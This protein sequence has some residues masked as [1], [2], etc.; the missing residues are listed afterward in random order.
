MILLKTEGLVTG[1]ILLCFC[2]II[3]KPVA[4]ANA[5]SYPMQVPLV[6]KN[7]ARYDTPENAYTAMISS[8]IQKDIE[9]YYDGLTKKTLEKEASLAEKYGTDDQIVFDSVNDIKSIYIL[10]RKPYKN[11]VLLIV[12][13]INNDESILQGPSIF[14]R[15]NGQ[16]KSNQETFSAEDPILDYLEYI[17]PPEYLTLWEPQKLTINKWHYLRS[18]HLFRVDTPGEGKLTITKATLDK[19][20]KNGF[21]FFNYRRI[22]LR[23]FFR[24]DEDTLEK[25]IVLRS[26]NKII[27]FLRGTPGAAITLKIEQK[28]E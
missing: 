27:L 9:W 28:K 2:I 12:K 20:I 26:K 4:V 8:L 3:F 22:P 10:D 16:W 5:A 25:K 11:G 1:A 6:T 18:S 24:G 13:T 21:L 23:N 19:R 17:P 15:E 14:V 7:Q